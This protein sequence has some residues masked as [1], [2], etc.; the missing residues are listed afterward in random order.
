[1]PSSERRVKRCRCDFVAPDQPNPGA[2]R[3]DGERKKSEKNPKE[4]QTKKKTKSSEK[5]KEGEI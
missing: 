4:P 1:M 2:D 3:K 5:E